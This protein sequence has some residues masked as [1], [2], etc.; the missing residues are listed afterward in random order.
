MYICTFLLVFVIIVVC[1][2]AFVAE[3]RKAR[4]CDLKQRIKNRTLKTTV[5]RRKIG[6]IL[7]RKQRD[8]KYDLNQLELSQDHK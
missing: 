6:V 1:T 3:D 5:T 4:I 7:T 2:S 8:D